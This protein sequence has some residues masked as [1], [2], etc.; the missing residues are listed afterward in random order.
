MQPKVVNQE[1]VTSSAVAAREKPERP[2][3]FAGEQSH[4]PADLNGDTM[5]CLMGLAAGWNGVADLWL[6]CNDLILTTKQI[7]DLNTK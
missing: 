5:T 3:R 6:W 4:Q 7:E 2:S 1:A